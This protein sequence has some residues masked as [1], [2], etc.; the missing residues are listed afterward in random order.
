MLQPLPPPTK[1]KAVFHRALALRTISHVPLALDRPPP[2]PWFFLRDHPLLRIPCSSC[3][4]SSNRPPDLAVTASPSYV[5]STARLGGM[6][7]Q[8]EH[9][10]VLDRGG[11]D[12]RIGA[13][14]L[15]MEARIRPPWIVP[16]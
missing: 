14:D 8:Q 15:G 6:D 13:R 2:A 12:L 3:S 7:A 4:T 16:P 9:Q 10:H 5:S 1:T 11:L